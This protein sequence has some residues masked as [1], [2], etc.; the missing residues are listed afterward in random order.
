MDNLVFIIDGQKV[1]ISN[2]PDFTRVYR[3]LETADTKKNNYSLTVKF[4]FTP[5]NDLVFKRTNSLSYKSSFPYDTHT[6]DVSSSGGVILISKANLVLL[7][8]TDSY[9]CAMTWENFDII[10]A[11]LNNPTKLGVLLLNSFP[12][13]DWNLNHSLMDKTYTTGKADTYGYL[14]Y[15]DGGGDVGI[16]S[17]K[18]YSYQH[19]LINYN[20]LLGLIFAEL[21][22]TLSIPTTKNDF[23]QSLIVRPNK[24]YDNYLNNVFEFNVDCFGFIYMYNA[25]AA[26]LYPSPEN[27][28]TSPTT[29]AI[30]NNSYYFKSWIDSTDGKDSFYYDVSA[31]QQIYRFKS[32]ANSVSTLTI[33]NFVLGSGGRAILKQWSAA[34]STWATLFTV[35]GNMSATIIAEEGDWFAFSTSIDDDTFKVTITT[36]VEPSYIDTPNELRFPSL[37]HIPTC[38]DMTVGE[39]VKQALDITCSELTYDVNS[40][41]YYFSERTKEN[42]SAYDITKNITN[43]KE[44]TYDTKY[45]Y[46]KLAESN[47]FKY[48]STSPINSDLT[49]SIVNDKLLPTLTFIY[50]SFN[51]SNTQSGGTYDGNC[52]A[53]EH[54]FPIG[55][56]WTQYTEQPLHLL[57]NNTSTSKIY[58]D[59]SVLDM[60]EIFDDF[61]TEYWSDLESL[62]LSGTARLLKVQTQITDIEFKR[63]NTKGNVYI[64]TYGKFYGIIDI[65]KNGDFAELFLLELF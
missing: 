52:V 49:I 4:P 3:G 27:T 54:T 62:V 47:Y 20:Y 21:G 42:G 55:Q 18:Y 24:E 63:I 25:N 35:S 22:L 51:T 23:L 38:I 59:T 48:L 13:L 10:G 37:F 50:L 9:E 14:L 28:G 61:W 12:V 31:I 57:Y 60:S 6:C 34:T 44:I 11:I 43:I 7:S 56:I 64:K 40:D 46:N 33:S 29:P 65:Y 16:S 32:F 39:Y 8:T 26:Y 41:T 36:T 2:N 30:G 58:F 15:N 19:P 5:T 53:I 45:I 1:D 17:T